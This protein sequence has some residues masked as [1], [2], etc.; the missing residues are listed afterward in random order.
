[1]SLL[2]DPDRARAKRHQDQER[3][4][5]IDCAFYW[6]DFTY[7]TAVNAVLTSSVAEPATPTSSSTKPASVSPP[8]KPPNPAASKPNID[9][10]VYHSISLFSQNQT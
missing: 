2:R 4:A 7:K 5:A 9:V 6:K 10:D 3:K 1:M 8:T